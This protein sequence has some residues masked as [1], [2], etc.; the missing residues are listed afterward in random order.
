MKTGLN[1]AVRVTVAALSIVLGLGAAVPAAAQCPGDV[2]ATG[3]IDG[4]DLAA[5]L[6]AWGTNGQGPLVTDLD[7]DGIVNGAD[8]AVILGGWGPC[9]PVITSILPNIGPS[10]GGTAITITGNYF[11]GTPSVTLGGVPAINVQLVNATTIAAVT[12]AS[13]N[14]PVDVT[15]TSGGRTA[16]LPAGYTFVTVGPNNVKAWGAGAYSGDNPAYHGQSIVPPDLGSC[17]AI[18]GGGTHSVALRTDGTVRAW[19]S[20]YQGQCSI[21]TNLGPCTAIAAGGYHTIALRTDGTVSAWGSNS[22]GQCNIPTNLGLC[23]AIAT[24]SAHT[25]VLRA[26]S[27][28]SAWGWN[29]YG[30][31]DVPTNL[32]TCIAI[33]GGGTHSVAL[34]TDGTVRAWGS[35][36][37]GQ[38]SIPTNLGP[39]TAIA[40]GG[41]HTIVL[42][43]NSTVS[44]WGSDSN[45]QSSIPTDLGPCAAVAAGGFHSIAIQR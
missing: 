2:V 31:C 15:V 12:P 18:A 30:E 27:T 6:G 19:G 1:H 37:Q 33:A 11:S 16:Y 14:G 28:V 44:A 24:G 40:A 17:T 38:C 43:A 41:Y 42:R 29:E 26:N 20:N 34:R 39:C 4:T 35:K 10:E 32:G 36:Y 21:P 5:V 3:G 13:S 45:G 23:I 22:F 9:A 25:I 8:L 7:G